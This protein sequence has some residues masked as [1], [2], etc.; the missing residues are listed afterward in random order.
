MTVIFSD[1]IAHAFPVHRSMECFLKTGC[2]GVLEVVVVPTYCSVL[3]SS[4]KD[5]GCIFTEDLC[6]EPLQ[7]P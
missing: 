2:S 5:H 1:N 3:K 4:R 6:V 7:S